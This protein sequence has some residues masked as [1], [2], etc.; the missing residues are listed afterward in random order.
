MNRHERRAAA[1]QSRPQAAAVRAATNDGF[2]N[3]L[4]KIG[5]GSVVQA[6]AN[7]IANGTTANYQQLDMLYRGSWI[8]GNAVDY[9]AEDMTRAGID[10]LGVDPEDGAKLQRQLTRMGLWSAITL[11]LKWARLYGGAAAFIMIDGQDPSTE[12]DLTTIAQEQFSGLK[13]F[14]RHSLTPAP[15]YLIREGQDMGLP[16]YYNVT[17]L[18]L[19]IHHSRLLRFVGRALPQ[20]QA[21]LEQGWGMSVVERIIDRIVPFDTATAGA[22]QLIQRASYRVVSVENLREILAQGGVAEENLIKM[23]KLVG[24]LQS[25]EGLTLIDKADTFQAYNYSFGGL[26]NIMLQFAQQIAG[27]TGI[28][29]VRLLGQS[30]A[31][32]N[33]TGDGDMRQYHE[34]VGQA[35]E[36]DLRMPLLRLCEVLHWS[37]LGKAPGDDFDFEFRALAQMNIQ[38]KAETGERLT[39]TIVEAYNNDAI[40]RPTMMRE[41]KHVSTITGLFSNITDDMIDEADAMVAE[42]KLAPP[43]EGDI[44]PLTGLPK[45]PPPVIADPNADPEADPA[46]KTDPAAKPGEKPPL[47]A[48]K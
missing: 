29:L 27:A 38:E 21:E 8:V 42:A 4:L 39:K 17:R 36:N 18:G 32:L 9:V 12:L 47:K 44:D 24:V 13:V 25:N 41:L 34:N 48:V 31:G 11:T 26:D 37:V 3:L 2:Q 23:F 43:G 28:P 15:N 20:I 7:Y 16:E 35:Q 19:T 5:Q 10:L 45:P 33:A 40:D 46:A 30:P 6:G 14:D 1:A 22:A